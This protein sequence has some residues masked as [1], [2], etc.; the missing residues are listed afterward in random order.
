MLE[1]ASA[2]SSKEDDNKDLP[3]KKFSNVGR[4]HQEKT[5]EN[6]KS[7]IERRSNED[8][9][10]MLIIVKYPIEIITLAR[11]RP[12]LIA[13]STRALGVNAKRSKS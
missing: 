5:S 12:A 6:C 7:L 4:E 11:M 3:N 1:Q 13:I 9:S 8:T 2:L 10:P